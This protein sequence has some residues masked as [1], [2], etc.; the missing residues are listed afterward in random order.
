MSAVPF[1]VDSVRG[2]GVLL[3]HRGEVGTTLRGIS[4]SVVSILGGLGG[5]GVGLNLVDGTS[6]VSYGF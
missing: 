6:V 3:T 4:F 5:C 1:S 2:R